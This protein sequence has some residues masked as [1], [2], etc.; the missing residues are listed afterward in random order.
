MHYYCYLL[1]NVQL[2]EKKCA[3]VRIFLKVLFHLADEETVKKIQLTY[4]E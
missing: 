1:Q 2:V 4:I 3:N